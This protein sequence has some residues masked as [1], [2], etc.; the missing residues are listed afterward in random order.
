V[1]KHDFKWKGGFLSGNVGQ[2]VVQDGGS[3]DH[4]INGSQVNY[5]STSLV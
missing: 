5:L 4:E 3:V 2:A 1:G